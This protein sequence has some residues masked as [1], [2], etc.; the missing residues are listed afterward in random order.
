[1]LKEELTPGVL[2]ALLLGRMG[3]SLRPIMLDWRDRGR[4]L[5]WLM[6]ADELA[7]ELGASG[8]SPSAKLSPKSPNTSSSA[9]SK[10]VVSLL[11]AGV[12]MERRPISTELLVSSGPLV[13]VGSSLASLSSAASRRWLAARMA[14]PS[15]RLNRA[16]MD[17][18]DLVRPLARPRCS[19]P[20]SVTAAGW[21]GFG[22]VV[23]GSCRARLGRGMI[24]NAAKA[25]R[26]NW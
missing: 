2:E 4:V 6:V 18:V 19:S 14:L 15:S 26:T 13:T 25:E 23:G 16:P 8:T 21:V 7:A 1:M 20:R 11:I 17:R 24:G 9:R 10:P 3:G 22:S 12:A 5:K